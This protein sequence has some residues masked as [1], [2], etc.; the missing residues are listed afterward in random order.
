MG[1][2]I[3]GR[4]GSERG[5]RGGGRGGKLEKEKGEIKIKIKRAIRKETHLGKKTSEVVGNKV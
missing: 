4:R 3:R 2:G 1:G 5:G